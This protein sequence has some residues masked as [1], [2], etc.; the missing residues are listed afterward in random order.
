MKSVRGDRLEIYL[1]DRIVR[2]LSSSHSGPER[3][4]IIIGQD[5]RGVCDTSYIS[6]GTAFIFFHKRIEL[7]MSVATTTLSANEGE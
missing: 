7:L 4:S 1:L 5:S 2:E 6:V 3:S